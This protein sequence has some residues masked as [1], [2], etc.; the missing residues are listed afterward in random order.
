MEDIELINKLKEGDEESFRVIVDRYQKYILN[1]CFRF[2]RSKETTEDLTQEVFIEVYRSINNFRGGSKFSTWIYRIAVTKSLD[3]LKS[4]KRKKRFGM[5][6]SL[7]VEN[8]FDNE[9]LLVADSGEN[10]QKKIEQDDRMKILSLALE[11]LPEKQRIAFT[12]NKY[13]EMSYQEIAGILGTTI[14]SVESLIHRA[15][16]NLRKKLYNYYKKHF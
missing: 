6:K 9:S 5:I 1:I 14:S 13:D 7:F 16:I 4:Q 2:T 10:P 15:K 12:L 11:S 3:H 8:D